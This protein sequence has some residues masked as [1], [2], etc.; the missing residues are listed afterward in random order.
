MM[1][2]AENLKINAEFAHFLQLGYGTLILLNV[3]TDK[4]IKYSL[5]LNN[6]V[7]VADVVAGCVSKLYPTLLLNVIAVAT[8]TTNIRT[9][10]FSFST[11]ILLCVWSYFC[12]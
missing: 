12:G 5:Q 3:G 9:A 8:L 4:Y 2:M 10:P 6:T 1:E 11:E 7:L